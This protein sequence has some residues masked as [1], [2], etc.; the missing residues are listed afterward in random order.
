M[1]RI[2]AGGIASFLICILLC[3]FLNTAAA[4][5]WSAPYFDKAAQIGIEYTG[6]PGAYLT[7][8]EFC[9]MLIAV[10]GAKFNPA[11]PKRSYFVDTDSDS[12]NIA[13]ELG[14]VNGAEQ[15]GPAMKFL[16]GAYIKRQEICKTFLGLVTMFRT[17]YGTL[18]PAQLN[19]YPDSADVA[20]WADEGV[21]AMLYAGVMNGLDDGR[22]APL[23]YTTAEQACAM[24][25]RLCEKLL[26]ISF[27]EPEGAVSA[28]S[29]LP[30][31]PTAPSPFPVLTPL[32]TA[33]PAVSDAPAGSGAAFPTRPPDD[34]LI[35]LE[36]NRAL[37]ESYGEVTTQEEAQAVLE[38][39]TVKVWRMDKD[40]N[41][42]PGTLDLTV[43]KAIVDKVWSVFEE[44]FNGKEQFPI[45]DAGAY[46]WRA[47]MSSGR[48]SEHN[49]GTAI[50]INA[51]ENYCIYSDG[52]TIGEYWKPGEDPYS[53]PPDGEVV[54]IFRKYG[55]TWGG[56]A[57]DNP[58]DF[59]HF[60]YMG[61]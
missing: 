38:T 32:P 13:Y 14:L 28:P 42:T 50:D 1:T 7:R 3:S 8:E 33:T 45:R 60:S 19:S 54:R 5:R 30:V 34:G 16:P 10:Y 17:D 11:P 43:H 39:V 37:I 31:L 22:I 12:V 59:M 41:K 47:P 15:I 26:S 18:T 20:D 55:F 2:H 6:D 46:S 44:I 53:I 40:G 21:R 57:W 58:K 25:V 24:T 29:V 48:L 23:A 56:N 49:W 61:R 36:A 51:N 52:S 35:D 4:D 9:D 27:E